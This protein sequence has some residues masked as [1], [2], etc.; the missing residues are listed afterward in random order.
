M[1]AQ[2]ILAQ[3]YEREIRQR[4]GDGL[5]RT[6]DATVCEPVQSDWL[7]L[8]DDLEARRTWPANTPSRVWERLSQR[9]RFRE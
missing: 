4:L 7:K 6:H 9:L 3:A 8:I 5:R 1:K 2:T